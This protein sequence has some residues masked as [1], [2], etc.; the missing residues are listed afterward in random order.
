MQRYCAYPL[1]AYPGS[2]TLEGRRRKLQR[3]TSTV[4]G[5]WAR[6]TEKGGFVGLI[7]AQASHSTMG[8][9]FGQNEP[10]GG[11]GGYKKV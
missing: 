4:A 1:E 8:R 6:D 9:H 5:H 10:N 7:L 2:G 3:V 11:N